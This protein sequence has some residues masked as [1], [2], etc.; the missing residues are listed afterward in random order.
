LRSNPSLA[1]AAHLVGDLGAELEVEPPV[2]DRPAPVVLD[3]VA[4]AE[5]VE[6]LGQAARARLEDTWVEKQTGR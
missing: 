4:V 3:V 1:A 5:P 6:Q 2:I